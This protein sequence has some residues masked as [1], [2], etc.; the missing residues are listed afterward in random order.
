M[1]LCVWLCILVAPKINWAQTCQ[2]ISISAQ[3]YTICKDHSVVLVSNGVPAGSKYQWHLGPWMV[4][5]DQDTVRFAALKSGSFEAS[6]SITTP[7]NLSCLVKLKTKIEVVGRP[8][9]LSLSISTDD[10]ICELPKKVTIDALGGQKDFNYTYIIETLGDGSKDYLFREKSSESSITHTFNHPGYKKLVLEIENANGCKTLLAYDSLIHAAH[11]ESP[12][13]SYDDP[14]TCD[15]KIVDFDITNPLPTGLQYQWKFENATPS[16]SQL[17]APK[18]IKFSSPGAHGVRLTVS[19]GKGCEMTSEISDGIKVGTEKLFDIDISESEVCHGNA[20]VLKQVGAN[21]SN[22]EIEWLL[23][24]GSVDQSQ[25]NDRIQTTT[26]LSPGYH[27]V[28]LKYTYGGCE[29]E[30]NYSDTIKINKLKASF[31]AAQY[32][33]CEPRAITFYNSSTSSDPNAKV[34][35]RWT[36]LEDNRVLDSDTTQDFTYDFR[37]FGNYIVRLIATSSNGCRNITSKE[38]NLR[39]LEVDFKISSDK[40]CLGQQISTKINKANTCL[41]DAQLIKWSI[42]NQAG[43]A[44]Y[45]F[46][47]EALNYK[48]SQTGVY[49]IGLKITTGN[50]CTDEK[51]VKRAIEVF[52]IESF[53]IADKEFL[54]A[55][56]SVEVK[57][58]QGPYVV[59]ATHQWLIIDPETKARNTGFGRSLNFPISRPGTYDIHLT[60]TLNSQCADTV[61]VEDAFKVSGVE[62]NISNSIKASCLPLNADLEIEVKKNIHHRSAS[63]NLTYRWAI[64][65]SLKTKFS[66]PYDSITTVEIGNAGIYDLQLTVK[67]SD[68]CEA[69]IEKKNA[70][71]AGVVSRFT[72]NPVACLDVPLKVTNRSYVN[73]KTYRW[74]TKDPSIEVKPNKKARTPTIIFTELGKYE[75]QLIAKNDI[76]CV[77]TFTREL[78]VIDFNFSFT[79]EQ[80]GEVLCAPAFVTFEVTHTNVDSF[81]WE[82]GD[83]VDLGITNTES[84]HFYDI[85]DQD[86]N[87]EYRFDVSL[88]AFSK[89]GCSDTLTRSDYIKLAGPRPKFIADP[90]VGT[91]SL[92]V[93][94]FEQNEG[95][96]HYLFDYGDNS[97]ID[98]SEMNIHTYGIEDS[99]VLFEEYTPRMVAFDPRGCKRSYSGAPIRI[100]NTAIARFTADTLEA[101]DSVTVQLSNQSVFADS[102]AWYLDGAETAFSHDYEPEIQLFAG[103][104][105][106]TLEVFNLAG[107]SNRKTRKDFILVHEKPQVAIELSRELLCVG[108]EVTFNDKSKSAN[109]IA[110]WLWDFQPS[111]P[112]IDISKEKSVTKTYQESGKYSVSL[113]VSDIFGCQNSKLFSDTVSVGAPVQIVHPGLSYVSFE[114]EQVLSTRISP[115]DTQGTHGFFIQE[116]VNGIGEPIQVLNQ[117]TNKPIYS[118]NHYVRLRNKEATYQLMAIDQCEDTVAVGPAHYPIHLQIDTND[119]FLPRLSWNPYIGWNG[120]ERYEV[121]RAEYGSSLKTLVTLPAE[122]TTYIDSQVCGLKYEYLIRAYSNDAERSESPRDTIHPNYVPPRGRTSLLYTTVVD[123]KYILTT[124]KKDPHPTI[125]YYTIART[126]PNFGYVEEHVVVEDTFYLDSIEVFTARDI[127]SYEIKAVDFCENSTETSLKGNSIVCMVERSEDHNDI[128]WNLFEDWPS[129][130]TTYYVERGNEGGTF[131]T[132]FQ[133]KNVTQFRDENIFTNEDDVFQYRIKAVFGQHTVYSNVVRELPDMKV[134]VPNAF[135]PNNDG[136]NDQFIVYGSGGQNGADEEVDN[137]SMTIFNRWGQIVYQSKDIHEGWD[138]SFQGQDSPPGT[139]LCNVEFRNKSG[140]FTYHAGNIVLIR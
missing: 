29:T 2:S 8:D 137:F 90:L 63:S 26:F 88:V 72:S 38:I 102:F 11:L 19:N 49:D 57:V 66:S 25:S 92:D 68:G 122:Q 5:N 7:T 109:N 105:T 13:I 52:Q 97:S 85:L 62:G 124:W 89:Y 133:G 32:C 12:V 28:G 91:Q 3:D 50:G 73:P 41:T 6:L 130:S 69:V 94:F 22:G 61:V 53:A 36:V 96:S 17:P 48:F 107:A 113:T 140:Q 10:K 115:N 86:P 131:E 46:E 14:Q 139:Y 31:S 33:D 132:I 1:W 37:S 75:L 129:A 43:T 136:V 135:T 112:G 78:E 65:D 134:Y 4:K 27:S 70:L 82:F 40:V 67:N 84:A 60:S 99:T 55:G 98:S 76:G 16:T 35:Y 21:L 34:Q 23:P 64:K 54:C 51:I 77:D 114:S 24:T 125:E 127:Y 83:G 58:N 104:H 119:N 95:V 30:V 47:G 56:D 123:N 110:S 93:E 15:E 111:N 39:P 20:V 118:G 128:E 87:N 121:L 108:K 9:T 42:Y 81:F 45:E 138:G 116:I 59:S 120:V 106:I 74:I 103:L 101:C 71:Y 18:N 44:V 100:Y 117:P 126:D 80:A 79:S